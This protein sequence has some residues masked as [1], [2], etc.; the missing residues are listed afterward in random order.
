M[1]GQGEIFSS[2]LG[3]TFQLRV[4]DLCLDGY[5]AVPLDW[6]VSGRLSVWRSVLDTTSLLL[7]VVVRDAY[8]YTYGIRFA[9]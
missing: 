1:F 7:L 9:V 4:L 6:F 3:P 5:L 2:F 8:I